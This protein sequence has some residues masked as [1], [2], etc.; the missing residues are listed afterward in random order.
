M[1]LQPIAGQ[2]SD[3]VTCLDQSQTDLLDVLASVHDGPGRG[4]GWEMLQL[5]DQGGPVL[6]IHVKPAEMMT[7]YGSF[8][9]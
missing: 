2:Y 4:P 7:H 6:L 3:H 5:G 1:G 9:R 8:N